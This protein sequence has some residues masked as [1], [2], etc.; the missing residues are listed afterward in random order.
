M[1]ALAFIIGLII[2]IPIGPLGQIII[3]RSLNRG[4]W[5]GFSLAIID[6]FVNGILCVVFLYGISSLEMQ[7]VLKLVLNIIGFTFLL[8]VGIK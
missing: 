6:A 8:F 3:N 5:H 1:V 7:P 2:A 4:F